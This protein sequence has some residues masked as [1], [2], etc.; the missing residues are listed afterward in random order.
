M[1]SVLVT[2]VG[3]VLVLGTLREVFHT[4]LH[5]GGRGIVSTAV[6]AGVWRLSGRLGDRWRSLAG[7]LAMV[8]VIAAW[9]GAT[10]LGWALVYVTSM[11]EAFT[12]ASD[13][14]PAQ[15]DDLIDALYYSLTTQSTLGY[16]DITPDSGTFRL[17]APLHATLGFGLFTMVV[18][19]VLS[20]YPALHRQ[21]AAASRAHAV[22]RAR[23]RGEVGSTATLARETERLADALH[24]VRV[25]LLQYPAT[26]W[27]AAP[28]PTMSLA[29]AIPGLCALADVDTRHEDVR[30]AAAELAATLE[31][32]AGTIG[33]HLGM[34]EASRDD[35]LAA[36]RAHHGLGAADL[37]G[38][39]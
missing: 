9:I 24:D 12:Y 18:T 35:V 38:G 5:P 13:L 37:A 20:I 3:V 2:A 22:G 16:G 26:F 14:E 8:L 21:R 28:G 34:P 39:R 11:P 33:E 30:E 19:W 27:F 1:L 32:L 17:L 10:V 15:E 29:E 25:D 23:S 4:L 36:Y 7:P 6:F 31:L